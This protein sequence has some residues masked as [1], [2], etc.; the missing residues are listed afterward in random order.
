MIYDLNNG[1]D[2]IHRCYLITPEPIICYRKFSQL[3]KIVY[4][5][6][7]EK[8]R[9]RR[10]KKRTVIKMYFKWIDPLTG[11]FANKVL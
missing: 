11:I 6:Q 10:R 8:K 7:K 3:Y 4:K 2:A 1:N 5:K 9:G